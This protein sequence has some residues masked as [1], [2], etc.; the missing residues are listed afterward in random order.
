MTTND[1][2][3]TQYEESLLFS[4]VK[5]LPC[6]CCLTTLIEKIIERTFYGCGFC[7][8]W[9]GSEAMNI[10]NYARMYVSDRTGD[11]LCKI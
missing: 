8:C 2:T 3:I 9:I 4:Q 11:T 7:H 10:D 5:E 6:D 1:Y